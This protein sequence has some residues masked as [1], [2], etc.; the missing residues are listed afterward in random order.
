MEYAVS[1]LIYL[2]SRWWLFLPLL[3]VILYLVKR[4]FFA[5]GG[6]TWALVTV[7]ILFALLS[8]FSRPLFAP[9]I[10]S[11]GKLAVG[12]VGSSRQTFFYDAAYNEVYSLKGFF[13]K[14][15]GDRQDLSYWDSVQRVYPVFKGYRIPYR[16]GQF[17]IL[18]YLPL[19]PSEFVFMAELSEQDKKAFCPDLLNEVAEIKSHF[20]QVNKELS[21][22]RSSLYQGLAREQRDELRRKLARGKDL[23]EIQQKYNELSEQVSYMDKKIKFLE[24]IL[25]SEDYCA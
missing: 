25:S 2:V 7:F 8:I 6:G 14:E 11:Y 9:I 23:T 10:N 19:M 15:N 21:E 22:L 17:F 24:T 18:K 20:A 5:T 12:E 4:V 3:L 13:Y 16:E 1:I